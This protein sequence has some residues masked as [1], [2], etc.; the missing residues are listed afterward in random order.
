MNILNELRLMRER[1]ALEGGRVGPY[2]VHPAC[3]DEVANAIVEATAGAIELLQVKSG[4]TNGRALF[5]GVRFRLVSRAERYARG[6]KVAPDFRSAQE[7][8]RDVG[9][10]AYAAYVRKMWK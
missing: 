9:N 4:I 2:F 1:A 6:E 3:L 10:D 5:N 8:M 7:A